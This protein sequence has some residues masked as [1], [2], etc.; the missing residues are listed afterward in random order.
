MRTLTAFLTAAVLS[1]CGP[2]SGTVEP[3]PTQYAMPGDTV[4]LRYGAT[5]QVGDSLR[6]TFQA[7][8]TDSRCPINVQCVWAGDAEIRLGIKAGAAA[9]QHVVLRANREPRS[10]AIAGIIVELFDVAPPR[11]E[12]DSI[13]AADYSV[14]LAISRG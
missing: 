6:I 1:A 8:E 4:E 3:A 11:V 10:T 5:A 2:S 12:P 7:V 9:W 13:R 14:R